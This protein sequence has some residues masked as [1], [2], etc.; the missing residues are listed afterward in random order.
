MKHIMIYF[1]LLYITGGADFSSLS[2]LFT[3]P[4]GVY[5]LWVQR[6]TRESASPLS[7]EHHA[8]NPIPGFSNLLCCQL[9]SFYYSTC[10]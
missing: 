3:A 2:Y 8:V 9:C 10:C 1:I 6:D 5:A 4:D 7:L